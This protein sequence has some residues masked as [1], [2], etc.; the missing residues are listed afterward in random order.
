MAHDDFRLNDV[1]FR[2]F[3]IDEAVQFADGDYGPFLVASGNGRDVRNGVVADR[4]VVDSDNLDFIRNAFTV[5]LERL[6]GR[7]SDGV[8]RRHD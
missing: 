3:A 8:G 5:G 4:G 2:R 7:E 6:N 1:V